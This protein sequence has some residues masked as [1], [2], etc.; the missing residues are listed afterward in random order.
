MDYLKQFES[1][2]A[3]NDFP[4]FSSLWEEYCMGDE[5]DPQEM[6]LIL[7]AAAQSLFCDAFGKYVEKGLDLWQ[8]VQD[9][10]YSYE[11]IK[12]I[13]DIQTTDSRDLC[14]F[15]FNFLEKRYETDPRFPENM[16]LIGMRDA[17]SC[18]AVIS[19][20]E[21]LSH[22]HPG[23]FVFHTAG[24][25]VGEI[26]DV[27]FL[28]E[29][30]SLE[31]DYVSG[32][33][34]LSFTNAFKTLYPIPNTHFLAMRFGR[35]DYLEELARENP[36]EVIH[37]VLRDLGPK[38][39]SDIK[40]EMCELVI[41]EDEWVKWW[42]NAR[43]KLKKDTKVETPAT[44]KEPFRLRE[45]EL[46]HEARFQKALETKPGPDTLIQLV[47]SHLRDFPQTLKNDSF[48][49]ILEEK[50]KEVLTYPEITP[51]EQLQIHYFL[52]DLA[53][54]SDY[55]PIKELIEKAPDLKQLVDSID[56]VANKKR[57][58]M[59]VKAHNSNWKTIFLDLFLIIDPSSL[60]ELILNELL[61]AKERPSI[62]KKLEE[63][64][65]NPAAHPQTV[66]W[67]FQK[68]TLKND[69]PFNTNDG[70][71]LFFEAFLIVMS[72]LE[73]AGERDMVKKMIATL[74][75][76]RFA[77]VRKIMQH[78]SEAAVHEFLLLAS[79]CHSLESH[80]LKIFHSLAE[81][82]HPSLKRMRRVVDEPVE[83]NIIWTTQ[84]GL[85]KITARIDE[86]SKEMVENAS[87]IE[88]ARSHGDLRENAEFKAACERRDKLQAEIKRTSDQV[89]Q[90]QVLNK[91]T[92][93]TNEASPGTIVECED[94]S[95]NRQVFTLLGP[96]DADPEKNIL[97]FQS[98]LGQSMLGKKVGESFDYQNQQYKI[99][100]I[101]NY[102][103]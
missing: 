44:A 40:D 59:M 1:H 61:A 93:I 84:K 95:Q 54:I 77:I 48:R 4:A 45:T 11:I 31:F 71:T 98:R 70:R 22:M 83:T 87:D 60:R 89:N 90:A 94:A 29:Q 30:L 65:K 28:R 6:C 76:G 55:P 64:L 102:F 42:Q 80:D 91:S 66:I 25:G 39:A 73:R 35:A 75:K 62:E 43:T 24:W 41:P 9:P 21:L 88:E 23:N 100:A 3:N 97:S 14:E 13:F 17:G 67:Y 99:L 46:S 15:A 33:K 19:K 85:D 56:L 69:L 103:G 49:Q 63:L 52:Q 37:M 53:D 96:W 78:A 58:L 18:R 26:M 86:I 2:V 92:V 57:T 68:V 32:L 34:D 8:T 50:L 38:T 12:L 5:I 10:D 82:V 36:C 16:R 74:T 81:V 7:R 72:H 47:Y 79:K 51:A 27:S 20:Y 101:K